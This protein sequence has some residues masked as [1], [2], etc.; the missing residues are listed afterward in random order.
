MEIWGPP[1]QFT[2][3]VWITSKLRKYSFCSYPCPLSPKHPSSEASLKVHE[4]FPSDE[5]AGCAV[6]VDPPHFQC[7]LNWP[8]DSIINCSHLCSCTIPS[9]KCEGK[10][11][12][13]ECGF[14]ELAQPDRNSVL[15]L[16]WVAQG[17]RVPICEMGQW[18][19]MMSVEIK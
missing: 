8:L 12:R 4:A 5:G 10:Q 2:N 14:C 6:I 9:T 19:L 3:D 11:Q 16:G 17:L 7:L 18:Y 15:Q 1:E 13:K